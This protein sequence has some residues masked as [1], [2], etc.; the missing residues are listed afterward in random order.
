MI[1]VSV[2]I[3][4]FRRPALL[5]EAIGS[6]LAQQG[7]STEVIVIDDSP[8]GSAR[9]VCADCNDPRINYVLNPSPSG[10]RPA[11]VRNSG[12]PLAQGRIVHFLDDDDRV[13]P[14]YYRAAV[15]T[16]AAQPRCGVVFGRIEPFS[17]TESKAMTAERAFFA[18]AARRA[19]V[20]ARLRAR[21]WLVANL[22]FYQTVLV[23]S[24]CLIRREFIAELGGYD[25][26]LK[27]NED[28]D[29]YCRAIRAHGFAFLDRV[30][31]H[32]RILGDSLMHGRSDNDGL[33][34]SYQRMYSLYR[35][36][37]GAAE[38]FALKLLARTV[39]RV[40]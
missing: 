4:T 22:L 28:V 13:A 37:H 8:E 40:V 34:Q 39:A 18:D 31:V 5:R 17:E 32:Y 26:E 27:L 38:L 35:A 9:S 19:R 12:W 21:H 1:D 14:G 30:V 24:A 15:E 11:L 23:N 36:K 6:A 29:F 10:G 33:V 2:V 7:V 16:F 3:P 20:A 25:P